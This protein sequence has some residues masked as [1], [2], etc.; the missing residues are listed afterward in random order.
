VSNTS[1]AHITIPASPS[2]P[3]T[4][5]RTLGGVTV[6]YTP[7]LHSDD[8]CVVDGVLTT[9]PSRTLVDLAEVLGCD[10]LRARFRQARDL[11]LL[12]REAL[13]AARARV[14]WR[15]SLQMFDD[16]MREFLE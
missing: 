7:S 1:P 12:D 13:A 2:D 10:E 11:G 9:S 4:R 5:E 3:R 14:E 6:H 16:V 8:L 15:P